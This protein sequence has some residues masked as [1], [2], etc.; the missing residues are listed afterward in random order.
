MVKPILLYCCDFWGCLKQP[1]NNPIEIFHTLFCKQLLGVRKQT[2]N[3]AVL[4]ELGLLPLSIHA[5]K[6][7]MRNWERIHLKNANTLLIASHYDAF[8]ENLPWTTHVKDIFSRNGLLETFLSKT[9]GSDNEG[10]TETMA[11]VILQRMVDQYNQTSFGAISASSKLHVFNQL[12]T[13]PGRETYLSEVEIFKHRRAMTRLRMSS[14]T[15]EI[16]RGRWYDESHEQDTACQFC[17]A[18]GVKEVEDEAHFLIRCPQFQELRESFL[19][20]SILE[21][22]TMT[23]EEKMIKILSDKDSFKSV[24]KFICQASEDRD[25]TLEVLHTIQ[26]MVK[27]TEKSH[28]VSPPNTDSYRIKNTSDDGLKI[29]LARIM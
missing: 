13:E 26:D 28:T 23:A 20:T 16:E 11:N 3:V 6:I 27:L 17:Q 19:P 9:D 24:A 8:E 4:Q 2:N 7:A 5:T 12:K 18:F 22:Q 25:N 21:N 14:H 10:D 1:K 15:L 29:T